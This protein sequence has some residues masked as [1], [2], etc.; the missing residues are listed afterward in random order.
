[1]L[2]YFFIG[3]MTMWLIEWGSPYPWTMFERALIITLWPVAFMIMLHALY[4]RF[5]DNNEG[6]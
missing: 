3:I 1:M 4:K 6:N 5:E 2:E